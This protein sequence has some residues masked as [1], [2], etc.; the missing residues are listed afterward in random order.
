M[1]A[2]SRIPLH[3]H[4]D[5]PNRLCKTGD[6][7]RFFLA[8]GERWHNA[9]ARLR[10]TARM[11]CRHCPIQVPCREAGEDRESGLWGGVLFGIAGD[12]HVGGVDLLKEGT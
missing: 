2:P 5:Y 12:G 10:Y 7:N 8:E 11:L 1:T 6:P 4:P 9:R 3:E